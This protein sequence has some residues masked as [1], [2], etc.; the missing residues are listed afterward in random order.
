MKKILSIA[1]IIS[2]IGLFI[3][4]YSTS[5]AQKEV[6]NCNLRYQALHEYSDSLYSE[7]YPAQIELSRHVEALHIF[8]KRNPKAANQYADIISE[9]TE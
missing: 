3:Q 9:E 7:M 8:M 6:E 5:K 2:M 1:L 4:V